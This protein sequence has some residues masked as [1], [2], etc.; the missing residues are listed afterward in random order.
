VLRADTLDASSRHFQTRA[1]GEEAMAITRWDPMQEFRHVARRMQRMFEPGFA[2]ALLE[3]PITAGLGNWPA[4]DVYEDKEEIVFRAEVPGMEQKDV[5]V[6]LDDSTL[7]IRGQR[8][9][10]KEEKRENYLRIEMDYG[11]FSRSFSLP[12]SIDRDRLRADLKNGV[13]EVHI[14]KRE[15][16]KGRTIPIQT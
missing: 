15:G 12:A 13:L 16:S 5:E 10:Q 2:G 6:V 11:T 14:P 9:M 4:V 3:E 8:R 1:R 7:T